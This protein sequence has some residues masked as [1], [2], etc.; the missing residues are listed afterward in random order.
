M[1]TPASAR[2]GLLE[3]EER[4]RAAL[5]GLAAASVAGCSDRLLEVVARLAEANFAAQD[6][7]ADGVRAVRS[8]RTY[9]REVET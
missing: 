4:M 8:M 2:H 9:L 5:N 3:V 1:V 6:A 7:L